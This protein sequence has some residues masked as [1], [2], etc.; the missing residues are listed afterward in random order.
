MKIKIKDTEDL[1]NKGRAIAG[2]VRE[3]VNIVQND[4]IIEKEIMIEYLKRVD[5]I[6]DKLTKWKED[7]IIYSNQ[8]KISDEEAIIFQA[9]LDK[10]YN[11]N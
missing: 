6:I 4:M 3:L 2:D 7:V 1:F 10:R 11:K 9:E 8:N 5:N